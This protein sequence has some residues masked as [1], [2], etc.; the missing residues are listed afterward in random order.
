MI[1]Y[2]IL[3]KVLSMVATIIGILYVYGIYLRTTGK[4]HKAS[5]F[6]LG[7]LVFLLLVE[8]VELLSAPGVSSLTGAAVK[9]TFGTFNQSS[10]LFRD[11]WEDALNLVVFVIILVGL[12][13]FRNAIM[14]IT[15]EL[16]LYKK[17][18]KSK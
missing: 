9:D 10:L 5:L 2:Y 14:K 1:Y 3:I 7:G 16:N 15:G 13:D 18:I 17:T 12:W 11:M 8:I 6:L 4:L